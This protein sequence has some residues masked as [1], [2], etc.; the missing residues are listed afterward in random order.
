MTNTEQAS[1]T[2]KPPSTSPN[3]WWRKM[4][5]ALPNMPETR[6]KMQS[7]QTGL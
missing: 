7:H 3:V 1:P 4:M 2:A 6:M 5:R